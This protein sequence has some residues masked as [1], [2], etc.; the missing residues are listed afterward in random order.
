MAR[1]RV[2]ARSVKCWSNT[3]SVQHDARRQADAHARAY[4]GRAHP[5]SSAAAQDAPRWH[6]PA[7]KKTSA[8]NVR[9]ARRT[10]S[11]SLWSL[12]RSG[13]RAGKPARRRAGGRAKNEDL[14]RQLLTMASDSDEA[15]ELDNATNHDRR[16]RRRVLRGCAVWRAFFP[17][18]QKTSPFFSPRNFRD[19]S[20][21]SRR[22]GKGHTTQAAATSY[23]GP[24]SSFWSLAT[25]SWR[26]PLRRVT[27]PTPPGHA[28]QDC[29]WSPACDGDLA[30]AGVCARSHPSADPASRVHVIS[31]LDEKAA[32]DGVTLETSPTRPPKHVKTSAL[33]PPTQLVSTSA[34][35]VFFA[36]HRRPN[37]PL[38]AA[39]IRPRE[40]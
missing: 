1:K 25:C 4:G 28:R 17:R 37:V 32:L 14:Q 31:S 7:R 13:L 27:V 38:I 8:Q 10:V 40:T 21:R 36:L 16:R 30:T 39:E 18:P 3:A 12:R 9:G 26:R 11:L 24:L 33:G 23:N 34:S 15:Q 6:S 2:V 29:P 35:C 19:S 20:E 22:K 5:L